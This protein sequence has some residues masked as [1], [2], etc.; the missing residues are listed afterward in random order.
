MK[1]EL[2][3]LD[4]ISWLKAKSKTEKISDIIKEK[5]NE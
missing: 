5:Q 1:K 2:L 4:I 3:Y